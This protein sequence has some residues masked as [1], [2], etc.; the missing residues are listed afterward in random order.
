M[1]LCC[2]EALIDMIPERLADG[3]TGFVPHAGGAIFNTTIALGRLG[4]N[5]GM[6]TGLS[7][8]LFGQQLLTELQASNVDTS[9][10]VRSERNTT[11]AFVHLSDGQATYDFLDEN[12]AGR[13]LLPENIPEISADVSAIYFGGISLACEPC[14][15]TYA[16]LLL[17]KAPD[18]AI[19]LDP[20]IRPAFIQDEARYRA[21]MA[22]IIAEC[23][24]V[25]VS[26]DDLGWMTGD[27]GGGLRDQ[28]D[29]MLA[30]GVSLVI[31]T[32]GAKGATAFHVEGFEVSV[33]AAPVRAVDTVGAGDTFNA[34]LMA[35]LTNGGDLTKAGIRDLTPDKVRA[36]LE[37]G[38]KVA[39]VTVSRAGANPPWAAEL[40]DT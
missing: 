9:T 31:V 17:R 19:M 26:D 33:P 29:Q 5:A 20:N 16:D 22:T 23:D 10:I 15:D 3:R 7:T 25:K 1:I 36:A 21:R 2:G 12:S 13:M 28:A 37:F 30:Q 39:A 11:L 32:Q 34:G 24:I 38:A 40:S 18:C 35:Q 14:A 6:L 8:D 27:T 4:V